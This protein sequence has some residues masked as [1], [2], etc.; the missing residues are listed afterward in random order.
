MIKVEN[1]RQKIYR[2]EKEEK[3][4]NGSNIID[5]ITNKK[6]RK[7]LFKIKIIRHIN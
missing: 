5:F 7:K 3:Y 2:G 4:T 1:H 6:E